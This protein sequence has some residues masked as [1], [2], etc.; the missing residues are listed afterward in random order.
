MDA[1]P[2][3]QVHASLPLPT[4]D[5]AATTELEWRWILCL[6]IPI[7][8]LDALQFS[9]K[10]YKWIRYAIGT[11]VGAEGH[12]ST[13]R[14]STA[15]IDYNNVLL[16]KSVVLYYHIS[17]A[18][19]HRMFPL[20]PYIRR[21]YVTSS[22]SST[23]ALDLREAVATRDGHCCVLTGL[24]EIVCDAV[25]LLGRSKGDTV[26]STFLSLSSLTNRDGG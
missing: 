13:A 11:V 9:H 24:E 10:P 3:V 18:E 17:P 8:T 4:V 16:A 22:A 7:A 15:S 20:D 19:R 5:S 25:H 21:A 23:R 14:D 26:R 12:L 6:I 1:T 2:Q